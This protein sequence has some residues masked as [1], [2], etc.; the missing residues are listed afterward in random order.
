VFNLNSKYK[1]LLL[2]KNT[3][4]YVKFF[5]IWK[6]IEYKLFFPK[7]DLSVAPPVRPISRLWE[8]PLSK[9]IS[10]LSPFKFRFLNDEHEILT[11]NDWNS[12]S[13]PKLWLYNL[14]YFD[15]LN[16]FPASVR[17]KW[18]RSLLERW[19]NEN[20]PGFGCGWEPYPIS[21]R[22]VNW[23]KYKISRNKTDELF[24]NSLAVQI[25]FLSKRLEWHLLGN[26]LFA[27]AKAMLFGGCYFHGP[28]AQSWLQIGINILETEVPEQILRDGGHFE[29]STMY[30]AIILE[31]LL[32]LVNLAHTYPDAFLP[33]K[34]VVESWSTTIAKM[35]RWMMAMSHPDG[36]I[37]FFNDAAIGIASSPSA[38]CSYC[39][40]LGV[41][42]NED[43][44]D[45]VYLVDSGYVRVKIGLAVLIID[46]AKIGPDYLP[47]HAHAD[48]LS[49]ELSLSGRRVLVNTGTSR[50]GLGAQREWERS[51]AAHNTVDIDGQSSS[52]VWAGFRVARR[53]YPFDVFIRRVGGSIIVEAAHDGYS[54][55]SGQ[56]IH[57]RRWTIEGN[58]L[59]VDDRIEGRFS[60]AI[61]RVYLHPDLNNSYTGL[62]GQMQHIDRTLSWES[63]VPDTVIESTVWHPEFGVS[64]PN[65]CIKM[66]MKML[67]NHTDHKFILIWS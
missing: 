20:P 40:Q 49:Y 13:L 19:I 51:T 27:N 8:T 37:S 31:D 53:A 62:V 6:R 18:H 44:S 54:R 24:I 30:H 58:Q 41:L 45:I 17:N 57:R 25:R 22:I 65:T 39:K 21:I 4:R 10:M 34:S 26:H 50:Y 28:E 15:D 1:K 11:P 55:L 52:E 42:L 7:P 60:Q 35:G 23:I 48:T 64:V 29:R 43:K 63:T 59:V 66:V 14:H 38:L 33:W 32:D 67:G 61:S 56:P 36:E 9:R 12:K 2:Y 47:G 3:L 5:Q 16:A 46:V